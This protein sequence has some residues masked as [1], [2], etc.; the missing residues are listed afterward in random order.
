[1]ARE[2]ALTAADLD[3]ERLGD[4]PPVVLVH[5]S[6]V[7]ARRTWHRQLELADEWALCI[8]NRPG[9]AGSPPLARGDFEVEAPLMA[10]LLGDGAHLV[11]HSYGAV[12]AL[13]A[14]AARPEAV[15]SLTVSEPGSLRLAAGDPAVDL[16][17]AQG[18]ELY[19]R[20]G[21]ITLRGFV[22]LFRAGAHSARETPDEL[23]DWLERGA[24]LVMEERPPWEAD[25]PLDDLAAA[26]FPKLVVSGDHSPAFE[27]V[28]DVLAERVGAERAVI[29][30]RGHTIPSTG[31]PY[32]ERLRAF[33][34]ECEER[35]SP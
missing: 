11:G 3:V 10:E 7:D 16:M 35:R 2:R 28:C 5:G 12:I 33:L 20:R 15:R 17:I 27:A 24:R 30:G 14:A 21:E 8:P 32:N 29:G 4:G 1:M 13:L 25:I 22:Q 31:A 26:P 23:P 9:F 18:D 6:I 19:R 34:V